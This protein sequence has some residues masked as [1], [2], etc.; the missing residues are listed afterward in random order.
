M[1]KQK[2][3]NFDFF[4]ETIDLSLMALQALDKYSYDSFFE[5]LKE[6]DTNDILLFAVFQ[7]RLKSQMNF[8]RKI[9][10]WLPISCQNNSQSK[11]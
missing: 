3:D 6:N 7:I 10:R 8:L 11:F 1:M 4:C 5:K 2:S 9:K